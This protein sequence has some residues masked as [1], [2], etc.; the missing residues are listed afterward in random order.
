M[1]LEKGSNTG[2]SQDNSYAAAEET[3]RAGG[4]SR[5]AIFKGK[6][7]KERFSDVF[8]YFCLLR[9]SRVLLF[10]AQKLEPYFLGLK[11]GFIPL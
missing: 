8:L 5:M 3:T 11:P 9:V 10:R 2:Q 7:A 1:G 4:S 6:E